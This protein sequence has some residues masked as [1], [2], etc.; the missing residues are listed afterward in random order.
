MCPRSQHV[1]LRARTQTHASASTACPV[2]LLAV[3]SLCASALVLA[4]FIMRTGWQ[5][6]VKKYVF[7]SSPIFRYLVPLVLKFC[8]WW[9]LFGSFFSY[10]LLWLKCAFLAVTWLRSELVTC[11]YWVFAKNVHSVLPH[12]Q[13]GATGDVEVKSCTCGIS[14]LC[15]DCILNWETSHPRLQWLVMWCL[16]IW[17]SY[18]S[19]RRHPKILCTMFSIRIKHSSLIFTWLIV[20][21]KSRNCENK[22]L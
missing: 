11:M 14:S 7:K 18:S 16:T 10:A 3:T 12:M 2:H 21:L 17:Q 22:S 6:V 1:L 8:S 13:P 9:F 5:L 20:T 4:A 19:K 15:S